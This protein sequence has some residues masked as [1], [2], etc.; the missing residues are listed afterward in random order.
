MNFSVTI[1]AF[2]FVLGIGFNCKLWF[3]PAAVDGWSGREQ[4]RAEYG[5]VMDTGTCTEYSR[6]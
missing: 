5:Y 1:G 4:G 2:C 6:Q 3:V